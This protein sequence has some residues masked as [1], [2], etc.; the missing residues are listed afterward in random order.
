MNTNTGFRNDRM[1]GLIK[2]FT[3]VLH[4][5]QLENYKSKNKFIDNFPAWRIPITCNTVNS[6][7][8]N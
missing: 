7:H 5:C 6:I 3:L 1:S 4:S 8:H 2:K